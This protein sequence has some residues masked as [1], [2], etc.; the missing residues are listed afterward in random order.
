MSQSQEDG[1]DP[2]VRKAAAAWADW[3]AGRFEEWARDPSP[4]SA[5]R[6]AEAGARSRAELG[7]ISQ[8]AFGNTHDPARLRK[9]ARSIRAGYGDAAGP[10][11]QDSQP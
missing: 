3:D 11:A 5:S 10:K 8:Q 9:V 2:A 1:L 7:R 4:G 6:I